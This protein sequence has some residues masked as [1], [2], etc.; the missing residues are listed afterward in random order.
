MKNS[1]AIEKLTDE[2]MD[3]QTEKSAGKAI[4]LTPECM[5]TLQLKLQNLSGAASQ[6][7]NY[8]EVKSSF[9]PS[10]RTRLE[11]EDLRIVLPPKVHQKPDVAPEK[12]VDRSK[13]LSEVSYDVKLNLPRGQWFSGYIEV[14]F[15]LSL[16]TVGGLY[17]DFNGV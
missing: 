10:I 15:K 12:L 17:L 16:M 8:E 7:A 11:S 1:K 3:I 14:S 9:C 2:M 13:C 5:E 4:E 6:E